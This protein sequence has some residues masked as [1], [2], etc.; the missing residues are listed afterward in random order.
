MKI[1]L[2]LSITLIFSFLLHLLFLNNFNNIKSSSSL[3]I[4]PPIKVESITQD[5]LRK[6]RRVGVRN[7]RKSNYFTGQSQPAIKKPKTPPQIPK[8]TPEK[9][10]L[11]NLALGN[12]PNKISKEAISKRQHI[13]KDID[14]V[15]T[16]QKRREIKMLQQ[17]QQMQQEMFNNIPPSSEVKPLMGKSGFNFKF[18]PIEGVSEDELNSTEKI[19][20][21]FQKRTFEKYYLSFIKTFNQFRLK[22]PLIKKALMSGNHFL[23]GQIRFDKKGNIITIR[24]LKSS[25]NDDIHELFE[26]TLK[27][28]GQMP[29]PPDAFIKDKEEFS[30][31]YQLQIKR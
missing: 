16:Y 6:Y 13:N 29:N 31:Y 3:K 11:R 24:I 19:F 20:F 2:N 7:G 30:I 25:P 18:E 23:T 4:S 12:K 9:L 22:K 26:E 28:I 21:S 10:D 15:I 8:K 5:E 27:E 14:N 17:Q 1:E